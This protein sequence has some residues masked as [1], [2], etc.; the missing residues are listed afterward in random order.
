MS[1]KLEEFRRRIAERG[2]KVEPST[3]QPDYSEFAE[4]VPNTSGGLSHQEDE[5][6]RLLAGIDILQAYDRWCGKMK[7]N[8]GSRRENIMISCPVP[9]HRDSNPSAWMNLDKDTWYCAV[10]DVGGDQFTI[11]GY[12]HGIDSRDRKLFPELKKR[13]AADLGYVVTSIG[14]NVSLIPPDPKCQLTPQASPQSSTPLAPII[15]LVQTKSPEE[16]LIESIPRI[17]WEDIVPPDTFLATWMRS[18]SG[19]DLPEEYFLWMGLQAIAFAAGKDAY[20]ND[21]PPVYPNLFVCLLGTTGSGKSRGKSIFHELLH[22]ALPY[23]S[24]NPFSSGTFVLPAP[25]SAETLVDLFSRRMKDPTTDEWRCFGNI[26]GLLSIDEFAQLIHQA[27][28]TG[29]TIREYL[30]QLYDMQPI[31]RV[32]ARSTGAIEALHPFCQ[33]LATTQ[34]DS[35]S[36]LLTREDLD[37]GFLNRWI[38]AAGNMRAYTTFRRERIN[39]ALSADKLSTLRSW[40]SSGRV[41]DL[42]QDEFKAWDTF[43]QEN[44][45][46]YRGRPEY[47][48]HQRL[49]LALKKI[50]T[51][52]CINEQEPQPTVEMIE[53]VCEGFFANI[54]GTYEVVQGRIAE[55]EEQQLRIDILQRT[56]WFHERKGEWPTKRQIVDW[57]KK[58][59]ISA[60]TLVKVL[61]VMLDLED[62][63][64]MEIKMP[65]GQVSTRY[66]AIASGMKLKA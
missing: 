49:D 24:T 34:N 61:K 14:K 21:E 43:A 4:V 38:F 63:I 11:A 65:S 40:T 29:N 25:G 9:G 66:S 57:Y 55:E 20:L 26:R 19:D 17:P 59:P 3:P 51:C 6:D 54:F 52:F 56:L 13:M 62:L 33:C 50:L 42:G 12:R 45:G 28:R 48:L 39:L 47:K 46:P 22:Q 18:T 41:F 31:I 23:D 16:T 27:Q 7:P 53:R 15:E 35:L 5:I 1:D 2:F 30:H 36:R 64:P 8:V 44:F 58:K 32:Q 60:Q 37:S 10:C